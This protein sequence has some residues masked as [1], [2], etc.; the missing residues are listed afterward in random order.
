M[1]RSQKGMSLVEIMVALVIFGLGITMALRMLPSSNVISSR[2]RSITMATNL[3][4]E[5]LEELM[6]VSYNH[7]DLAAG[8]HQDPDNPINQHY[9]RSW[10]VTVDSPVEGMKQLSISVT[11]PT[12]RRDSVVTLDTFLTQKR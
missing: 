3:A 1:L 10:D 5:K 12:A 9:R 4:S 6:S 2:S 8:A 7:T 11:F